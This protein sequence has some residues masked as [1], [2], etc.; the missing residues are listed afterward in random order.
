LGNG[1]VIIIPPHDFKQSSRWYH[2]V[3]EVKKYEFG[4]VSYGI[5]SVPNFIK[6][7]A[8]IIVFNCV[9]TDKTGDVWLD[10][11]TSACR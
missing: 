6:I 9:Q 2:Q 4:V 8:D 5:T 1:V 3:L 7:V 11:I 10:D